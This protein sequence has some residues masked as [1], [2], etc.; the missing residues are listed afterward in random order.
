MFSECPHITAPCLV[1]A[2]Y[3]RPA[4]HKRR[5]L[6]ADPPIAPWCH[7]WGLHRPPSVFLSHRPLTTSELPLEKKGCI[8]PAQCSL[9]SNETYLGMT[10][11]STPSCCITDLC[12][13]AAMPRVSAITGIAL[14]VTLW[15]SKLI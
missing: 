14:L 10:V 13:S 4:H 11:K 3:N 9:E 5:L 7:K 2:P 1:T 8:N 15:L 12:N 6:A